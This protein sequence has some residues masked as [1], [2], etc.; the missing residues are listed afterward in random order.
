MSGM[1]FLVGEQISM[2]IVRGRGCRRVGELSVKLASH[3]SLSVVLNHVSVDKELAVTTGLRRYEEAR[4]LRVDGHVLHLE[5]S[6][7]VLC[8][9]TQ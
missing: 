4:L 5:M 1:V 7:R 2:W 6:P 8:Q 3:Q 9:V